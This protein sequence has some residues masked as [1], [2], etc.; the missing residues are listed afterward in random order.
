VSS[1]GA[2]SGQQVY[3]DH[4]PMQPLN[5]KATTVTAVICNPERTSAEI[6]GTG[7]VNGSG[8]FEYRIKLTDAG[9]PGTGDMYGILIPGVPY[10]SGDQLLKGGNVQIR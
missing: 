4:G 6:Y 5:F 10:A 7:T 3:Q 2:T 9:E 8:S 1:T